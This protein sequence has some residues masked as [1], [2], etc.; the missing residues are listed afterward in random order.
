[1]PGRVAPRH[2][3]VSAE[4]GVPVS[5]STR[6]FGWWWRMLLEVRRGWAAYLGIGALL[7]A[8]LGILVGENV[9]EWARGKPT[10]ATIIALRYYGGGRSYPSGGFSV[11][12]KSDDG[13]IAARWIPPG[14][15]SQCKVG[16]RISAVRIGAALRLDSWPCRAIPKAAGR[17]GK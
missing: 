15:A 11:I 1:M 6:P 16:S 2:G 9:F 8:M 13:L 3:G 4:R 12:A 7:V 17:S 10:T 5:Q 14:M